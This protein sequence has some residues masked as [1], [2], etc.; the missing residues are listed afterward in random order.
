VGGYRL[1]P[2]AFELWKG[3]EHRL[4]DRFLYTR[5]EAGWRLERLWP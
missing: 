5:S 1:V 4:H 3:R 2:D